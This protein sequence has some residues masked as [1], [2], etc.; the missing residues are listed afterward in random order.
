M[1]NPG[2]AAAVAALGLVGQAAAQSSVTIGGVGD[3]AARHVS[4]EGRG[5]TKALVSGANS[6][7][8]LIVRGTEDLGGGLSAGFHLEHGILLD[9]GSAVQTT[10]FWDRRSTLSLVSKSLGE[11]RAGRDFVPSY[12]SWSRFDPFAYVGVASSS[13]FVSAS[14]QGP[15]RSG[16]GTSPNTTVRSSNAVQVLLPGGLGGFEGGLMV[17][18]GEGGTAANGQHK[19]MGVRLGYVSGPLNTSAAY[20][21]SENNLTAAGG[22]FKDTALG[23]SYNFEWARTSL[24]MRRFEQSTAKQ[25]NLIL[26]AW[27]P[28]G[29]SG[30]V[31]VSYHQVN[32]AGAVGSTDIDANDSKQIGV[33]YVHALSKRTVLYGTLARVDNSGAATFAVPGGPAGLAGGGTSTGAE[34]G[35]RHTF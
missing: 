26:G 12:T 14:P 27:I 6:T 28:A 18:A 2:I 32:L 24:A 15:I 29:Q 8:R 16:F 22:P 34:V 23:A 31:K 35:F 3:V 10:Q 33:G 5:S 20:T 4:N 21:R 25:T 30:E 11:I 13:N 1:K 9:T 7:S 17:A 19:V